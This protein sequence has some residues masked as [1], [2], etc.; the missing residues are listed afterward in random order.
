MSATAA[1]AQDPSP[2]APGVLNWV[3]VIGLGVIWGTAFMSGA[4]ALEG[5]GP[6]WVAA[7]RTGLAALTLAIAGPFVGQG[8]SRLEGR[9]IW[10]FAI[11]IGVGAIAVPFAVLAW[12]LQYVPSAFAGV[13][14]GAVP[15]LT[16]P[17]IAIFSPEEGIGPR[18]IAGVCLGFVGLALLVGPGAFEGG[19]FAGR[20]GCIVVA[21]CYA[22]GSIL[23]RRAPKAPP[24]AFATATMI[25]GAI[26]LLPVAFVLEGPPPLDAGWPLLAL[27]Y[28]A[29]L[30][31]GAAAIIR[32]RVISTAGSLFMGL[33]SYMVPVWSV[34]F[35]ITLM[36][37]TLPRAL[38]Y[39][40]GLILAGILLIQWRSIMAALRREPPA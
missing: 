14:M 19:S 25:A 8:L 38:F 20:M 27:I 26:V 5:Y 34:I 37:E 23:T 17:L 2:S 11:V 3:L 30:P 6:W 29:I 33:T 13:A 18:R 22:V 36:G 35:G 10:G 4:L 31:T 9:R 28:L 40:L 39:A 21:S 24:V 15:L 12:A 16:L 7:G 32:V 1:S